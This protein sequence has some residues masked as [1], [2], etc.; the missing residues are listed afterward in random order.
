MPARTAMKAMKAKNSVVL[1]DA[2]VSVLRRR[3]L[4]WPTGARSRSVRPSVRGSAV[5]LMGTPGR[6]TNPCHG[7]D[8]GTWSRQWVVAQR[9]VGSATAQLAYPKGTVGRPF[10]ASKGAP[11][12]LSAGSSAGRL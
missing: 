6:Q 9:G 12:Y 8:G 1:N 3:T 2:L 7:T 4:L 10:T 5:V 11:A